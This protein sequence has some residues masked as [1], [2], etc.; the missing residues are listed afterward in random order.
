MHF[1]GGTDYRTLHQFIMRWEM[2]EEE[3]SPA[4][5]RIWTHD[6]SSVCCRGVCSTAIPQRLPNWT[7]ILHKTDFIPCLQSPFLLYEPIW[8]VVHEED[9]DE[10]DASGRHADPSQRPPV[11]DAVAQPE[12]DQHPAAD[13]QGLKDGETASGAGVNSF[14]DVHACKNS[15]RCSMVPKTLTSYCFT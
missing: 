3:K 13:E 8:G 15:V 11:G 6:L 4:P 10:V 7:W 2:K 5:G 1:L 12:Y 14:S 9:H